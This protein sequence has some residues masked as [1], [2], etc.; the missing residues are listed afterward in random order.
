MK[1][2]FSAAPGFVALVAAALAACSST[3]WGQ[4]STTSNGSGGSGVA[5]VG[6]DASRLLKCFV[7]ENGVMQKVIMGDPSGRLSE[8]KRIAG[9]Q[10]IN[11]ALGMKSPLRKISLNRLEQALEAIVAGGGKPSDR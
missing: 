1:V 8:Q 11:R 6:I 7:D 2:R 4:G 10:A 9:R 3:A 5:G